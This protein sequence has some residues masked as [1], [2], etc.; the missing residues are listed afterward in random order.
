[1]LEMKNVCRFFCQIIMGCPLNSKV[2][3]GR[4]G[5]SCAKKKFSAYDQRKK[6]DPSKSHTLF[7]N[8]GQILANIGTCSQ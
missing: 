1:M 5:S 7:F 6:S 8:V 2:P 4:S 3:D